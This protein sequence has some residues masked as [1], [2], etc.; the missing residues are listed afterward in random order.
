MKERVKY[1]PL[2]IMLTAGLVACLIVFLN[3][4]KAT[5]AMIAILVSLI[6]FY[7]VGLIVK[8]LFSKFLITEEEEKAETDVLEENSEGEDSENKSE[9]NGDASVREPDDNAFGE[10]NSSDV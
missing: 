1:I 7:I 9:E 8:A 6:I 4:Y 5:E 10:D 3:R 2:I